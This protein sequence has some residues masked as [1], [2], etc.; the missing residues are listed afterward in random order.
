MS[1][2]V[3]HVYT[4][5][6][7]LAS[8]FEAPL[9]VDSP[10][11]GTHYP[12][13]FEYSCAH[14]LLKRGE[15]LFVDEL[16]SAT[17]AIGGYLMQALF[18]RSYIDLN[19]NPEDMDLELCA[20]HWMEPSVKSERVKYGMGIIRRLAKPGVPVYSRKLF[21]HEIQHRLND[22]Y[23]VYHARLHDLVENSHQKFGVL[24]HLNVHSM[25]SQTLEGGRHPDFVLGDRDGQTSSYEYT[26]LV[27]NFL[28]G[29]GFSVAI[30][31]PYKGVEI[32][33]RHGDPK[34]NKNS[35]QIEINKALY[36]DEERFSKSS[37]F[38]ALQDVL[39]ELLITSAAFSREQANLLATV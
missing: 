33:R 31:D 12:K 2:T 18:S 27:A 22:Y 23:K 7:P 24:M 16:F 13:D 37:D 26:S 1:E 14:N 39:K 15:D 34:K 11:S 30:N 9:L 5:T 8:A 21:N 17:P 32:V 3:E 10:H 6:S 35:I 4:V 38:S 36:M 29:K 28:R 25:P 20:D 19:R